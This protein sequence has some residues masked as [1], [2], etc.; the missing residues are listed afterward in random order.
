MPGVPEQ[1]WADWEGI[2]SRH[3]PKSGVVSLLLNTTVGRSCS[4]C[5]LSGIL[6]RFLELNYIFWR[7]AIVKLRIDKRKWINLMPD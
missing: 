2:L 4:V 6:F 7:V 1:Q 5:L 3:V